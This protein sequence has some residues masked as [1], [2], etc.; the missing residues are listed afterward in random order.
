MVFQKVL[1]SAALNSL[2]IAL[3]WT[4]PQLSGLY[5]RFC[6]SPSGE[7]SAAEQL[8]TTEFSL[9]SVMHAETK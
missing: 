6:D 5:L 8:L 4:V 3:A 1:T 7:S 2:I 9:K